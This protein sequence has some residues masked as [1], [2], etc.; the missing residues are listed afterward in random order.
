M[1]RFLPL[2]SRGLWSAVV[3]GFAA[4]AAAQSAA[5]ATEPGLFDQLFGADPASERS[6]QASDGLALP[7][8]FAD[9]RKIAD[10]LSVYDLGPGG[11]LCITLAPLLDA[12]ELA[13]A[14]GPDGDIS[15][16]LP[17]PA[18]TVIIPA[19]AL[20]DSPSG[21]CIP[22]AA[23]PAHLP[24]ALEHD[25]VGQRLTLTAQAPLPVLM[26]LARAERQ[27]RI[28]PDAVRAAFPLLP[29]AS[30]L[31]RL[32]SADV[33]AGAVAHAGGVEASAGVL[34]S[35]ELFGLAARASA[36]ISSKGQASAGFTLS[37]TRD[38]PDLL[39]PLAARS[40]ALGD[41]SSPPQPMIGEALVGRGI[42]ISSR[43]PW[44][45][46]LVDDIDLFGPLPTGWEAELWHE[47]RLVAVT[48]EADA[49][50]NWRFAGLPVRVGENRWV[51]KLFGPHGETE[52]QI[53]SRLVGT[54]M[55]AENE[56]DYAFG[57]VD[58][59]RPLI[60]GATG[61]AV[62]GPTAYG[63]I[64]WGMTR[65]VTARF[66]VRASLDG[67]VRA[68]LGMHGALAGT[69]WAATVARDGDGDF[70]GSLRLARR[71]GAQ[72]LRIDLARHGGADDPDL[73]PLVRQ[74][75][76]VAAI[77]GQGR[78]G[79]G[80]LSLPWQLRYQAGTLRNGETQQIVATRISLPMSDWQAS[81]S[82]GLVREAGRAWTGNAA[83]GVTAK[84]GQWRLR[85]GIDAAVDGGFRLG[86][87]RLN[88]SRTL[89]RGSIGVDLDWQAGSNRFGA[90]VT[91][92]QQI[93]PFS[94]SAN[95]AYG[96]QGY[97]AGIN[98]V[99]G[100]WRG[101]RRWHAAPAGIAR[102][103][104]IMADMFVDEN[105]DGLRGGDEAGVAGGR[106]VVGSAVRAEATD[107]QGRVLIRGIPAGPPV[108]IET[109]LASLPDF[110]LRPS[111]AGDRVEL[112]PG[113]VRVIDMPLRPTGSIEVQVLLQTGDTRT[114][115]AGMPVILSDAGGR[116][117][118]RAVTDFE[119]YALF[120]G[121]AFGEWQVNAAGQQLAPLTLSRARPNST[122]RH[123][124]PTN[125]R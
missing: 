101:P 90:G 61:R 2:L 93:G 95:V 19:S 74:F 43:A 9:G 78:F 28:R 108:D 46:D 73:P 65:A 115:R 64:G 40:L 81:G 24:F 89:G 30:A 86:G 21:A 42:V 23:I 5:V 6:G 56:V 37:D 124:I 51:V 63:T 60:D 87:A 77:E 66:D 97:R 36:G 49:A 91:A 32:Y 72:D 57:L 33:S 85:S 3:L 59:G 116:E 10:T 41:V 104:A 1:A 92:S 76:Q 8:L 7:A 27:A 34:A 125:G 45:A 102:S 75:S 16:T 47:D 71:I 17:E 98:L 58:G 26:R 107:A 113:E 39:G 54:E 122:A 50:G 123:T 96:Q 84:L 99:V 4:P 62:A 103:G 53:F 83:F 44:R 100:L 35:G 31:A 117:V 109:Q 88:A 112:R 18:R 25:S 15:V 121:L 14:G 38:T 94:L 79:L 55:N 67:E 80:R 22:A 11:G 106:F 12:L 29:R 82:L 119:G 48:R 70:G 114:P 69:L 118:A 13:H 110:T 111:R 105:G 68:A 120:E 20:Q 52:E